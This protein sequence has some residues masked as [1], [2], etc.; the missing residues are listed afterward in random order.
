MNSEATTM[1][2][3]FLT[4]ALAGAMALPAPAADQQAQLEAELRA[5][6]A[7]LREATARA[8][9][10]LQKLQAS[11]AAAPATPATVVAA[12]PPAAPAPAPVKRAPAINTP[13]K[14]PASDA[15]NFA[16]RMPRIDFLLQTRYDHFDDTTRNNTF[17][18]RKAELGLKGH[19]ADH[20]DYSAEFEF[21]RTTANDP[22]RRT[23]VRFSH[24][25]KL[26]VKVGM[27]KAPLGL[28]ELLST[29]TIPF[30]D[31]SEVSDRFAAA[32]ELGV[33]LESSWDHWLFQASLTNGGRRLYRDD[34]R[35]LAA[36]GRVVWAPL[37]RLSFGFATMQGETGAGL[38]DR[39]R[40]V[41]EF[42]FGA[43][44]LQGAQAEYYRA[45][46]G[47]V[48]S[49]GYYVAGFWAVPLKDT[50]LTHVQPVA[51]YEHLDRDDHDR[52]RELRLLTLG[53]SLLLDG[54]N[55]KLQ[56]NWLRDLRSDRLRKDELR[57]QA[58]VEF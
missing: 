32:E 23:Y 12:T 17:F 54:N 39:I 56:F 36:T 20:I 45:K 9:A 1:K 16:K 52:T 29:V 15:K 49:D 48:W 14:L 5:E 22:Y 33:F 57:T 13:P 28:E 44:N 25:D 37:E 18:L 42:K 41:G 35:R 34:N 40:Y 50:W 46:D 8:E 21:A 10:F 38:L 27:E 30:V 24:W 51:R 43:N 26:H 7:R 6:I 53:F 19:I 3:I 47:L 55:A 4:T 31:R 11:A 2:R 58:S